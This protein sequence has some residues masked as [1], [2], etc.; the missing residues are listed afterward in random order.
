MEKIKLMVDSS[1]DIEL[2][3]AKEL[4]ID[5]IPL[6]L[7]IDG[8]TYLEEY[9]ISKEE[10]WKILLEN[11]EIPK[12]SQIS[13]ETFRKYYTQAMKD[14]YTHVIVSTINAAGSGTFNSAN[15]ARTLFEE[16]NP[17]CK[18]SIEILDSRS[19]TMCYGKAVIDAAKMIIDGKSYAEVLDF[20]KYKMSRMWAYA[21]MST[22]KFAKK[23]GR[24][25]VLSA[26]VGEALKL[27]PLIVVGN[28]KV[29]VIGKLRG[30]KAAIAKIIECVKEKAVDI[31]NQELILIAGSVP[32]AFKQKLENDVKEKLNPKSV[33][34]AKLGC[35]IANNAGPETVGIIFEGEEYKD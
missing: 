24:I 4:N 27:K 15:L 2:S 23:S 1:C 17:D 30:D 32:E 9:D 13:P 14:G 19:Y 26:M 21:Y 31:E 20:L 8:K 6:N 29:D 3:T 11:E 34:W 5:L 35:T 25:S 12:T 18:M 7:I 10:F 28:R 33:F 22:L 16:E